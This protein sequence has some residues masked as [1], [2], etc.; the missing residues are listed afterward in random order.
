MYLFIR[1]IQL[2]VFCT[3]TGRLTNN[4]KNCKQTSKKKLNSQRTH[5]AP[6]HPHQ[7][8]RAPASLYPTCGKTQLFNA[9]QKTKRIRPCQI[10]GLKSVPKFILHLKSFSVSII[11]LWEVLL[12]QP[13]LVIQS[14]YC[15]KEH[16][17]IKSRIWQHSFFFFN[18]LN[19]EAVVVVLQRR[20]HCV[21]V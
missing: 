11:S 6:T 19:P 4:N 7:F 2:P 13:L 20:E 14:P 3:A 15:K 18:T 17:L 5:P 12:I 21:V 10:S 1:L 9:F 8:Y 16:F